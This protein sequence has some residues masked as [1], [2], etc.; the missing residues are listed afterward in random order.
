MYR[1]QNI[2]MDTVTLLLIILLNTT[3]IP[4]AVIIYRNLTKFQSKVNDL[5][6][7]ISAF[8][9][10]SISYDSLRLIFFIFDLPIPHFYDQVG[11]CL[12]LLVIYLALYYE[13]RLLNILMNSSNHEFK[14]EQIIRFFFN[15]LISIAALGS[16]FTSYPT[17]TSPFGFNIYKMND[18]LLYGLMGSTLIIFIYILFQSRIFFQEIKN[19][20]TRKLLLVVFCLV[21]ILTVD[22][23]VS[24]GTIVGHI[25][26][27]SFI[28]KI[29]IT[30]T[31]S[32]VMSI[33]FLKYPNFLESFNVY[34]NLKALHVIKNNGHLVYSYNFFNEEEQDM[35]TQRNLLLGGIIYAVTKGMPISMETENEIKVLEFGE[36]ILLLGNGKEVFAVLEVL[37]NADILESKLNSFIALFE[38][39]YLEDLKNWVGLINKFSNKTTKDLIYKV[40]GE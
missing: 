12:K 35:G 20:R 25:H 29:V 17:E 36:E 39:T 6:T 38:E 4:A 21:G 19:K 18:F 1:I 30:L 23:V 14:Y 16:T 3:F 40:F 33:F 31:I 28:P 13:F 5:I 9:G 7:R 27:Y 22:R 32:T 15:L 10:I 8:L 11:Y 34:L 37:V 2:A 26:Y 24:C